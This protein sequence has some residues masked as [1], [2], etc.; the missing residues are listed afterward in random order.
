MLSWCPIHF[1]GNG[2]QFV[3][4]LSNGQ[5]LFNN[6]SWF[7]GFGEIATDNGGLVAENIQD[8]ILNWSKFCFSSPSDLFWT[9]KNGKIDWSSELF[10]GDFCR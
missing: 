8:F 7:D 10:N 2:D 9:E 3:V 5:I 4:D 6:H 1:E